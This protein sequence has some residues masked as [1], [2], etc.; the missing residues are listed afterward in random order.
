MVVSQNRGGL[1]WFQNIIVLLTGTP[2]N[3][4]PNFGKPPKSASAKHFHVGAV[5]GVIRI[6]QRRGLK[7]TGK[8]GILIES[9]YRTYHNIVVSI[10]FS[11][12]SI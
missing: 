4:S 5:Y 1:L 6:Y 12:F 10:L 8:E 2:Q 11:I 7:E 9:L 3:G